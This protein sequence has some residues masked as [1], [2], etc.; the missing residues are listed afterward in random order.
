MVYSSGP[1]QYVMVFPALGNALWATGSFAGRLSY[2][3][4]E[5]L[6]GSIIAYTNTTAAQLREECN[7]AA[8]LSGFDIV[9]GVETVP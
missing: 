1:L 6:R 8:R 7:S 2:P 9:G 5:N 3:V 4:A